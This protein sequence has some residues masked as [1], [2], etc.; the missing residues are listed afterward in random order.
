MEA[1]Q[2]KPSEEVSWL[3]KL[4]GQIVE[5]ELLFARVGEVAIPINLPESPRV[6]LSVRDRLDLW[7]LKG[8]PFQDDARDE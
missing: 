7:M 5:A 2:E 4:L 3:A 6:R 1:Y 8:M